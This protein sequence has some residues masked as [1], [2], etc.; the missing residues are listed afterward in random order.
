MPKQ[1]QHEA[2][3]LDNCPSSP[4]LK[5]NSHLTIVRGHTT[6]KDQRISHA[7][8]A[9]TNNTHAAASVEN[10][11]ETNGVQTSRDVYPRRQLCDSAAQIS[12][13]PTAFHWSQVR[14]TG[15]F[16]YLVLWSGGQ[17]PRCRCDSIRRRRLP[18]TCQSGLYIKRRRLELH[19]Q[20]DWCSLLARVH[21][22]FVIERS[23]IVKVDI[24]FSDIKIDHIL[25]F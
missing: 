19:S 13:S 12:S 4:F 10:R 23:C 3:R 20:T 2:K 21:S 16:T 18:L 24:I 17:R 6:T 22:S 14:V 15:V 11:T 7:T 5:S 9:S 8:S 1:T 25:L